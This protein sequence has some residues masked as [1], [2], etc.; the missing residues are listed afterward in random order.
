MC[1]RSGALMMGRVAEE[2]EM[3]DVQTREGGG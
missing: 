1:G 3:R 2:M